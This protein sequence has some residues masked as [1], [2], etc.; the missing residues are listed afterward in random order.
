M[1]HVRMQ[2]PQIVDL[3]GTHISGST[4]DAV[5]NNVWLRG[6]FRAE[7]RGYQGGI[8]V[9]WLDSIVHLNILDAHEQFVTAE[10]SIRGSRQW[11]FTVVYANPDPSNREE[12]WDKLESSAS[13]INR[14]W[15]MA[16]DFNETRTLEERDHGGPDMARRCSKFNNW[17][18][19][20][21]LIDIGSSRG[22]LKG[23]IRDLMK[24]RP[25]IS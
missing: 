18:E 3:L 20:N 14:P 12:L 5:C 9:L 4:V 23:S 2:H 10:I 16:G 13:R 24:E 8:W 15:L 21:A 7:A 19:N 22:E 25:G 1:E 11:L 6:Q 17:I